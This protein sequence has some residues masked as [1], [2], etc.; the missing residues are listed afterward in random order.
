MK[1]QLLSIAS[2][3]LSSPYVFAENIPAE[4]LKSLSSESFDQR[5][6]AED[7]L[8]ELA[9]K[10][11]EKFIDKIYDLCLESTDPEV[12]KRCM[13]V[14]RK[15]SDKNYLK[16]GKGFL[17][18]LMVEE[19]VRFEGEEKVRVCVRVSQVVADSPAAEF[20]L[21]EKDLIIA[22]DGQKWHKAG[23]LA[24][25][26]KLIAEKKP[27]E[28]ITLSI[29]RGDAAE[30]FELEV[31]LGKRPL[32]DLRFLGRGNLEELHARSRAVNFNKWLEE[33]ENRRI[34]R[35]D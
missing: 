3:I 34:A 9:A 24:E 5:E 17:G 30:P 4:L 6:S 15:I 20:G 11:D 21:K 29:V 23:D 10:R 28:N 1:A 33:L 8:T 35:K 31:I 14:L 2:L 7:Q 16:D 25:F 12:R 32:E 13:S 19:I 26:M 18:I 22:L 27:L